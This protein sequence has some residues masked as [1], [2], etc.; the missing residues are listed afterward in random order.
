MH[1]EEYGRHRERRNHVRK[2][3]H[4]LTYIKLGKENGGIIINLS[5]KGVAVRAAMPMVR[6]ETPVLLFELEG[7]K[8][9]IQAQGRIV[10][11]SDSSKSAGI[12]FV[13]IPDAMRNVIENWIAESAP[14]GHRKP[15]IAAE[16]FIKWRNNPQ[17]C[18]T[19]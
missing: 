3:M 6:D 11:E 1:D 18:E 14:R 7:S 8:D 9:W 13:N 5:E 2:P 16:F 10:W 4:S 12:Q 19:C 17:K 15:E